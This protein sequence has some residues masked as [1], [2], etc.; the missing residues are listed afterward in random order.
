MN[1]ST[2]PPAHLSPCM[3]SNVDRTDPLST[4]GASVPGYPVGEDHR[5][6]SFVAQET[7]TFSSAMVGVFRFSYLRNKFLFDQHLNHTSPA[8]LGFT[9]TPSLDIAA[10][11][12]FI[13]VNGY[14]SVG[15][16]ITGPRDT[17]ENAFDF[18]G[19]VSWIRGKHGVGDQPMLLLNR[20][21][22]RV[23]A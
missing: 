21:A 1:A 17:Y 23:S 5:A 16:P 18:S 19:S 14:T 3:F 7:H 6:Q 20:I 11:P 8:D 4:A 2:L 15:D 10:G 12:P 9:Y 22:R 13:Q